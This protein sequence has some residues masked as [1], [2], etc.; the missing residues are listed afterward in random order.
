M[1][2]C[3][4][5]HHVT[6]TTAAAA[7]RMVNVR[8]ARPHILFRALAAL[9]SARSEDLADP[10]FLMPAMDQVKASLM[11]WK[12]RKEEEE[13]KRKE[14]REEFVQYYHQEMIPSAKKKKRKLQAG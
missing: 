8:R 13:R 10:L 7:P 6:I 3:L 5:Q 2:Q 14:E 1:Y 9:P 4:T 11:L 12:K